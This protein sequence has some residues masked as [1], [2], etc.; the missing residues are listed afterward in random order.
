MTHTSCRLSSEG[1]EL[2]GKCVE[3]VLAEHE[4]LYDPKVHHGCFLFV[5][6]SLS[7][8]LLFNELLEKASYVHSQGGLVF[9]NLQFDFLEALQFY[10]FEGLFN[11]YA[12]GLKI[13]SDQVLSVTTTY[14]IGCS[15]FQGSCD[16][17]SLFSWKK[18]HYQGFIEWLI[19][20]YKTPAIFFETLD[21]GSALYQAKFE[22][23]SLDILEVTPF[24]RHAKNVY[25][26]SILAAYLHRLA[27]VLPEDILA[28]VC[29]DVRGENHAAY[30][31]QL[32]SKE[33]FIHL[34]LA[35]KG[36]SIP[37]GVLMWNNHGFK[38]SSLVKASV[39]ICFPGDPYCTSSI[40]NRLKK[41][42]LDL[43]EHSIDYRIIPECL[44]TESWHG[45]DE[46]IFIKE[47]LS[48][49]GKRILQG[50]S[51]AG[52]GLIYL[53]QPIGLESESS[54]L[55]FIRRCK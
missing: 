30:L 25:S 23:L 39:A 52:G 19:D 36:S 15:L 18:A 31:Y 21:E 2:D 10:Y 12:H 14:T 42:M 13:F 48:S 34:H 24:G 6:L 11:A 46:L 16:F 22:E 51:V 26:A 28:F 38:A 5:D 32:F 33:R 41:C 37:E 4:V 20:I 54:Y 43:N 47:A 35:I 44:I 55:E 40:L 29:S 50:F 7:S 9:W 27:A 8:S 53:D 49:Q 3:L 1:F 17:A 45:L